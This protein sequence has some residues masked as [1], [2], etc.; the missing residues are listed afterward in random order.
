MANQNTGM[1]QMSNKHSEAVI[2]HWE[3]F[4]SKLSGLTQGIAVDGHNLDIATLVAV[5]RSAAQRS[6]G[7]T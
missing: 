6:R 3:R 5:A 1:V 2:G 7:D 4:C